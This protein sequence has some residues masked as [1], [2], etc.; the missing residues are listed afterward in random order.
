MTTD[1]IVAVA[2]PPGQGGIGIVR[3]SGD[4]SEEILTA[5]FSPPG[6]WGRFLSGPMS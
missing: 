3:L 2:T 1:T 5:V 4:R 6:G